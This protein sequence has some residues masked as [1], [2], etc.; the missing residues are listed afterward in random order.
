MYLS[1]D[2]GWQFFDSYLGFLGRKY[3][4]NLGQSDKKT[5][6][7]TT[8]PLQTNSFLKTKFLTATVA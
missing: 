6:S 5:I 4:S 2:F 3:R 1:F 8:T 7:I